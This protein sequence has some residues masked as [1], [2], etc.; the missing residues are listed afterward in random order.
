LKIIFAGTPL[1]AENAL[2]ALL[3]H[4]YEITAVLTQ[5]DRPSGRGLKVQHSS[6]KQLA[7][8]HNL[9]VLQP[10]TL[11]TPEIQKILLELEAD[12]IVVA[13]YGLILPQPVLE[14]PRYGC[15]NIHASLLPRWR[16]A[17]PIQRVIQAGDIETGIT[18][19][20]MDAGLDTGDILLK[21]EC[22]IEKNETAETLLEK[23]AQLGAISIIDALKKLELGQLM[24]IPQDNCFATYAAKINKDETIIDWNRDASEINRN[25][26][27]YNPY[28]G[29]CSIINDTQIKIWQSTVSNEDYNKPGEVIE[30]HKNMLK[31]GC[32]T[33]SLQLEILQK[34]N[35]KK[36]PLNQFIQSFQIKAGDRFTLK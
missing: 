14:I 34:P 8:Q 6:V 33:G 16:G 23:L 9:T 12:V 5:P 35:A 3:Q 21:K 27:A 24:N 11:K 32:G 18:I 31:V 13:A 36:L 2:H 17:A 29:A 4:K 30:V 19:M 20:Q 22:S 1:F 26:R 15:L 10:P 28:P 7:L 25:I